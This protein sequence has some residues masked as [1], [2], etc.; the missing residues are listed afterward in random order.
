VI[1]D[2]RANQSKAQTPVM[3]VS[4][5]KVSQNI[6]MLLRSILQ[7]RTILVIAALKNW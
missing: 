5:S 4:T 1:Q 7:M 3:T 6:L 2:M